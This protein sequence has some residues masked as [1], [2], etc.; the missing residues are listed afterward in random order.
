M[1][2]QDA[3]QRQPAALE[4]A[5]TG[6]GLHGVFRARRMETAARAKQ[7][8][9]PALVASQQDDEQTVDHGSLMRTGI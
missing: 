8:T 5:E 3:P 7:R 6:D 2:T 9:D 4:R 1:A